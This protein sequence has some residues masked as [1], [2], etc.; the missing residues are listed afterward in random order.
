MVA[1]PANKNIAGKVHSLKLSYYSSTRAKV[2]IARVVVAVVCR[3]RDIRAEESN[4][5]ALKR[6]NYNLLQNFKIYKEIFH[7]LRTSPQEVSEKLYR[8][9]R[10][11]SDV[12]LGQHEM[13]GAGLLLQ[14][15]SSCR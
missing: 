7:L 12:S 9:I 3:Y 5:E 6:S 1:H 11:G 15:R 2:H 13:E 8:Q 4:Y 14:L 10:A